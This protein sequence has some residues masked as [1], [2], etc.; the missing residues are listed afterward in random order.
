[1]EKSVG[2]I[3]MTIKLIGIGGM[4]RLKLLAFI[5]NIMGIKL[6]PIVTVIKGK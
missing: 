1:M 5:A 6:I 3:Y 4:K 2:N